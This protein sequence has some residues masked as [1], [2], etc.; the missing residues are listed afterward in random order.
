M[1]A[2]P[3]GRATARRG[4][5]WLQD[6]AAPGAVI[7]V[8][9][10]GT[11]TDVRVAVIGAMQEHL[12]DHYV[13]RPGL[14]SLCQV[15]AA[16]LAACNVRVDAD[17]GVVIAAGA[18]E[19]RFFALRVLAPKQQVYLPYKSQTPYQIATEFAGASV[20]SFEPHGK[21]P[22]A[23][24]GLLVFPTTNPET[25]QPYSGDVLER[26]GDWA[27]AA[28]LT[29]VADEID[30]P[31]LAGT[32]AQLP[33]AARDG[34]AERTLTLGSFSGSPPHTVGMGAAL[35]AWRVAWFAGPNALVAT[36]RA[37]KQ[38]MTICSP[39]PGQYAALASLQGGDRCICTNLTV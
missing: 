3:L 21:L 2:T 18:E 33:L 34:F 26:I 5:R 24:G 6:E 35:A 30:A 22:A 31:L 28:D 32:E 19:A 7:S 9:E 27:I 29:V 1:Q 23:S 13:R 20:T 14:A 25:G 4:Q 38:A 39:A 15:I 36:V 17:D 37:L 12:C 16:K 11:S 10:D 8:P